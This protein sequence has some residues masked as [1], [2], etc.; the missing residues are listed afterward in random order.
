MKKVIQECIN[1]CKIKNKLKEP[2]LYFH[3]VPSLPFQEVSLDFLGPLPTGATGCRYVLVMVDTLT[4]YIIAMP[5]VDRTAETV[6][7]SLQKHLFCPI[8]VPKS[9]RMDNAKEFR[10]ELL[11]NVTSAYGSYP[12]SIFLAIP[13][14]RKRHRG[15]IR[16]ESTESVTFIL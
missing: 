11:Q 13:S 3:P 6:I 2:F 1:C 7:I 12:I 15:S 8:D 16:K 9:I 10:S 5:T 14:V 4:R